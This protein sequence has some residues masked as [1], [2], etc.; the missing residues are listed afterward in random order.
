M[1]ADSFKPKVIA[2]DGP[3]GS[4]KSTIAREV[5]KK[6]GYIYLDTGAMYRAVTL[7]A[8]RKGIDLNDEQSL[9]KMAQ[10]ADIEIKINSDGLL[11]VF[12]DKE[13]V[14]KAIRTS[15]VTNSVSFIARIAGLREIMVS[16][17]RKFGENNNIVVEGRDIGTVVFPHAYKK[18]YL[19][20]DFKERAKRRFKELKESGADVQEE[21]IQKDLSERDEKD[22]TRKVAPL[23]KAADAIFIDTTN[24]TIEEVVNEVIKRINGQVLD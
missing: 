11:N 22:L 23:K 4:G 12:L 19:D 10:E 16:L 1:A 6:L 3:A 15:E 20:A 18:F 17:Q 7:K 21:E 8:L 13:D 2:I 14:T 24:L 9:I 5:A